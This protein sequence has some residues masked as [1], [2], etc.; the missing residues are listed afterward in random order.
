MAEAS[1]E[2]GVAGL[3]RR[4]A[5]PESGGRRR[6]RRRWCRRLGDPLAPVPGPGASAAAAPPRRSVGGPRRSPEGRGSR[7][8][9]AA[10]P[11]GREPGTWRSVIEWSVDLGSLAPGGGLQTYAETI[12]LSPR[13]VSS[14]SVRAGRELPPP[15]EVRAAVG[16]FFL[17]HHIDVLRVRRSGPGRNLVVRWSIRWAPDISGRTDTSATPAHAGRAGRERPDLRG[18]C[19]RRRRRRCQSTAAL[20]ASRRPAVEGPCWAP[21]PAALHAGDDGGAAQR[22]G[23]TTAAIVANAVLSR[24]KGFGQGFEE[25]HD[26]AFRPAGAVS[27]MAASWIPVAPRR[28]AVPAVRAL[29]DPVSLRT[30]PPIRGTGRLPRGTPDVSQYGTLGGEPRADL[31]KA[32]LLWGAPVDVRPELGED[33]RRGRHA[34]ARRSDA[35]ASARPLRR[36]GAVLGRR[37]ESG[38]AG[39]EAAGG[40]GRVRWWRCW[41]TTARIWRRAGTSATAVLDDAAVRVPLVLGGAVPGGARRVATAVSLVDAAPVLLDLAGIPVP[42]EMEGRRLPEI[43]AGRRIP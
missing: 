7:Y 18:G 40:C 25:F 39:A 28:A 12:S 34:V 20:L 41:P 14:S 5:S 30:P 17:V 35:A 24:L 36:G 16:A 23:W 3:P 10:S 42:P 8:A 2:A 15:P 13:P 26:A 22:A 1:L 6:R 21:G 31:L 33:I 19:W 37:V 27:E 9:C 11:D 43:E 38:L 32:V 4:L 29:L